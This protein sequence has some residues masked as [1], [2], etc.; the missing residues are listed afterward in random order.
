MPNIKRTARGAAIDMDVLR[1]NNE[2]AVA[3]GNMKVNAR[4]DEIDDMGRIVRT[5]DQI[6]AE[7]YDVRTV[8]ST[9]QDAPVYDS[10]RP[11]PITNVSSPAPI[12]QSLDQLDHHISDSEPITKSKIPSG[13]A[14]GGLASAL[15]K[16]QA[17]TKEEESNKRI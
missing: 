17:Q 8:V 15:K 4:G 13:K 3:V 12:E 10:L 1:L 9:V 6:I 2:T 5:R 14:R 16:S 7:Q 11:D